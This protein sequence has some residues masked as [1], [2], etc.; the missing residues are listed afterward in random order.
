MKGKEKCIAMFSI[1]LQTL[2]GYVNMQSKTAG[3]EFS[4]LRTHFEC[5]NDFEYCSQGDQ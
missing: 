2:M 5:K 4:A 3:A 1:C